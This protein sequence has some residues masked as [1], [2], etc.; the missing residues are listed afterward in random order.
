[1][2]Q[3][4]FRIPEATGENATSLTIDERALED[5]LDGIDVEGPRAPRRLRLAH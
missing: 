1:L 3:G 5:L 2:D 4:T